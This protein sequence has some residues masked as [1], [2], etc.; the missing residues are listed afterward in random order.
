[1]P[2]LSKDTKSQKKKKVKDSTNKVALFGKI[3]NPF[4]DR[5]W[6]EEVYHWML[7]LKIYSISL[8]A[9]LSL[10]TMADDIALLP[11]CHA[12]ST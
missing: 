5:V 10:H 11:E 6:P 9:A 12:F 4:I 1:M 8:L 2:N 3:M 7:A